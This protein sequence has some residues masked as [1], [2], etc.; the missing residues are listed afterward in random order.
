MRTHFVAACAVALCTS[1]ALA[2]PIIKTSPTAGTRGYRYT[3]VERNP[4]QPDARYRV[5]FDLVT[6]A[7]GDVTAV[8]RKAESANGDNWSTPTVTEACAKSLHGDGAALAR[9]T[10]VTLSPEAASSLGEPFM[11]MCAPAAYFYPMTDILNVVLIQV[12]PSFHI[13]DLN[14]A[15]A[16]ARF[17]GFSTKL[18]RLN[19]GMTA[20]SPGG[21]ITLTALDDKVATVD[22][23]PDPMQITLVKHATQNMPE[24]TL[25]GFERFAFRVE[26][27]RATGALRRSATT[28]DT[29]DLV[30]SMP[31]LP[32]D[33]APHLAISREVA[34]E[35]RD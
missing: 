16:S 30:V 23:A 34:I 14:A 20:S 13:K 32:P 22:W 10:L 2:E 33:K 8:I 29:L 5:D 7:H 3:S 35:P 26:V 12:S 1:P 11:A 19:T 6:D 9:V 28:S 15:G 31:G 27:E 18:D 21:T 25:T 24:V 17:E 4:G